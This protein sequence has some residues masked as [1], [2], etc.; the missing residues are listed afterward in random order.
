MS[1]RFIEAAAEARRMLVGFAAIATV[2]EVLA[3]AGS[4]IQAQTEAEQALAKLQ[5]DITTA[6]DELAVAS[7]AKVVVDASAAETRALALTAYDHASSEAAR[8]LAQANADAQSIVADAN[9][10]AGAALD[11]AGVEVA[12]LTQQRNNLADEVGRLTAALDKLKAAAAAL[13]G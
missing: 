4:V 10:R 11:N 7:Q 8:I 13:A 5:A 1:N 3:D 9:A 12:E 2:S 6:K